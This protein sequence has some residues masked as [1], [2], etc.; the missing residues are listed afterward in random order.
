[1]NNNNNNPNINCEW[2]LPHRILARLSETLTKAKS[3]SSFFGWTP[4]QLFLLMLSAIVVTISVHCFNQCI[5]TR[6]SHH[7]HKIHHMR[8][9]YGR[10]TFESPRPFGRNSVDSP[11]EF[12]KP[13]TQHAENSDRNRT[14]THSIHQTSKSS[15]KSGSLRIIIKTK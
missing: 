8:P 13:H 5:K 9:V 1:M 10:E 15:D 4:V 7:A 14:G 6:K 12:N 3:E 11:I 2:N